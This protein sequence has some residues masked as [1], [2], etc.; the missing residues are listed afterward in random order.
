MTV[1]KRDEAGGG[2]GGRVGM[3]GEVSGG[4]GALNFM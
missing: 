2:G 3:A 1:Q 4:E